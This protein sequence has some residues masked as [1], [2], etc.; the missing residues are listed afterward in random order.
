VVVLVL[1]FVSGVASLVLE[2]VFLRE[3]TLYVGS[4]VTATSLT[5]ATFLG[6]LALGAAIFG[7]VADKTARPLRLYASLELGVALTGGLAAVVLADGRSW[8]LEP[9]RSFG[10]G[11]MG[12][13]VAAAITAVLLLPPTI[14]MG[15]T[16]PA[17]TRYKT[18]DGASIL[19]SLAT[20][21]GV[22]TLG[23]SLG[24]AL[25]GFVL[26][27]RI[28]IL[29]TGWLGAGL[30]G[31]VGVIALAIDRRRG[32]SV[33]AVAQDPPRRLAE[34]TIVRWD[35][36]ARVAMI[37]AAIGGAVALGYEVV[38]T[39][40]LVLPLRSYAYSFS[41]MLSLFLF[42]IVL[43]ALALA[44]CEI[45]FSRALET[46]A[47]VQLAAASYVA[48][49]VWWLPAVLAPPSEGGGFLGLV[50][51]ALLRAGPVVIPPTV[52]SGMALPLA[53]RVFSGSK[54][55]AG[56][57]AGY[58]YAANTCGAIVGA[59][60]AGLWLLP[61]LGAS[62]S[63][64]LLATLGAASGA[65]A[66]LAAWR[67]D[68]RRWTSIAIV[69]ACAVAAAVPQA[70]Y[71][72][73]FSRAG[74]SQD[75]Q[76]ATLFFREGATDTVAVVRRDYGFRDPDAKS[77]LV[78][79][80]AMTATVKPVWRYMAAEGHLPALFAPAP[81]RGL[82]VCVGTGITLGA[83]A[84]HDSVTAIDAVDLSESVLAALPIF[85]REN[86]AAYRDPKVTIVHADGRHVLE[87]SDRTYGLITLEPPPPIVAGS[88]HLYTLDFYRLCRERLVPGGVVAQWLPLHAQSLAS[89]KA[90]A[91]TFLEAFP[92]VGLWLPSI[93]DAVLIGSDRPLRLD[94]DRLRSAYAAPGTRA[95]LDDAYFETPE[96]L[97]GTYL[98][99][100]PGVALWSS[101]ADLVTDDRPSIEFFRR[102][103]P[104]MSDSEIA[105]LLEPPPGGIDELLGTGADPALRAA[106]ELERRAHLLYLR[107]A[108][109][110]DAAHSR[111][112]ALASRAT[113]FGLY[114]LGCDGPQLDALRKDPAGET[115]WRKQVAMCRG[116]VEN[117]R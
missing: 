71:V 47:L 88:V 38:W 6:G 44:R 28:G 117:G 43:G 58:V 94:P 36:E 68:A 20:L 109:D 86:R 11:S 53:V 18:R 37:V 104:T 103:G 30:A 2:T 31:L 5:L 50:S 8:L 34:T 105:T 84:S 10:R 63:L 75:A 65:L 15:G 21:Y 25:A 1:F 83:L 23:A 89:A 26:F 24:T 40:L 69:A 98:L 66:A 91:R 73:A 102:Y 77:V 16:L 29:W 79:G 112:A 52:L 3:L 19:G 39:R 114:R 108:I 76:D 17:L 35:P 33:G 87:L 49:S 54:E 85:A 110:K 14:L 56:H 78:N 32:A 64:A 101:G 45:R 111:E 97:L 12:F 51:T 62:R 70:P 74:R 57:A 48:A 107:A 95:S 22:N 9:V 93:R 96:A 67:G 7:R 46:L 59:L 100:R 115:A 60:A 61:A 92:Y 4:A 106:V 116:L 82:V 90:T 72:A 99:D 41:L 81:S 55:L 27:E 113:H 13:I 42:G 80:I